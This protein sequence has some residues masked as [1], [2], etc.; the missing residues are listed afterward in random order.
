MA[1]GWRAPDHLAAGLAAAYMRGSGP[2]RR[3]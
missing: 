1:A 2:A 3:G